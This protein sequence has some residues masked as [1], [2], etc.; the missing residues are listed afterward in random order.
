MM[1]NFIESFKNIGRKKAQ[2]FFGALS[3]SIDATITYKYNYSYRSLVLND[4]GK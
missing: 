2:T 1:Q 3:A 4:S